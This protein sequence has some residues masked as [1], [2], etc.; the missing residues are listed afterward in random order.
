[1]YTNC[2]QCASRLQVMASSSS[3]NLLSTRSARIVCPILGAQTR[4]DDL[5][6]P[7]KGDVLL[8][9]Q[10]VRFDL[11]KDEGSKKEPQVQD[12]LPICCLDIKKIWNCATIPV[13][14]DER[15]MFKLREL[16]KEYNTILRQPTGR[17]ESPAYLKRLTLFKN[18]CSN[19]FDIAACK[20]HIKD[21]NNKCHC[22]LSR[23]VSYEKLVLNT[24]TSLL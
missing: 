4:L 17:K 13:I 7:T 12:I 6:L 20:C 10:C 9:Y 1:M 14:T 23:K 19:L 16:H 2:V 21:S 22:D 5:R 15:I 3:G 11:R 24:K 18:D 8:H